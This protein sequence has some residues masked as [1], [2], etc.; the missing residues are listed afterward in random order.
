MNYPQFRKFKIDWDVYQKISNVPTANL[1]AQLYH[2]CDDA[3]QHSIV[4]TVPNFFASTGNEL[5]ILKKL[6][7]KVPTLLFID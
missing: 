3:L 5:E 1:L 6:S 7:Q 4:N 2:L